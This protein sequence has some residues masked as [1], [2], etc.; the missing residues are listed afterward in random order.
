MRISNLGSIFML[1]ILYAVIFLIKNQEKK[2]SNKASLINSILFGPSNN[3]RRK[4]RDSL[5]TVMIVCD[6]FVTTF[7]VFTN[8]VKK[9]PLVGHE[10]KDTALWIYQS[11]LHCSFFFRLLCCPIKSRRFDVATDGWT[12]VTVL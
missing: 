2:N 8:L 4:E 10:Y 7:F 1:Y 11:K 5:T 3:V 6:R 12:N 9:L